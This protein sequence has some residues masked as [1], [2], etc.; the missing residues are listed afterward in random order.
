VAVD[1]SLVLLDG[2]WEHRT[3]RANGIAFHVA[4]LGA[5]PLVLLLHG[6]PQMWW[7][8]RHQLV[9]L[10]D[11]GFRA[12]AVDQRGCGAS[13]KPPRGYDLPTLAEDVAKLVT[14]L[15]ERAAVVVGSGLGGMLAW[16][17]AARHPQVVERVAVLGAAHPLRLR[18]GI[19]ADPRGQGRA[20]SHALWSF[21]LPR[22]PEARLARD[23]AYARGLFDSWTGPAWRASA[24]YD[25]AVARYA[26]ALRIHA[27]AHLC[28]EPFR[29]M[30]RS[31]FRP[32]GHRYTQSMRV[33]VAAP[34]LQ[35]HGRLDGCV[36][37]STAQGSERHVAGEYQWRALD[38]VGHFPQDEAPQAVATELI[39][40]LRR[41]LTGR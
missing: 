18:D 1:S 9:D 13:D 27:V 26:E 16:T 31:R 19:V 36:L 37:P 39:D 22:W 7:A 5:G 11:A 12:V 40:W 20:A 8:W 25:A 23:P 14:A 38:N 41:P 3:V 32:D 17:V 33:P 15:G 30:V 2:P 28:L 4:E 29:W 6:F 35:L 21:Q 34:V 10:A 24:E